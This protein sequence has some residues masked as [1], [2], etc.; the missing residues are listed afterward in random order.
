MIITRSN[1]RAVFNSDEGIILRPIDGL[2]LGEFD[3]TELLTSDVY[4]D[5]NSYCN[6]EGF[7]CW[8]N[9]WINRRT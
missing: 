3:G 4:I 1:D 7:Y 6:L 8:N 2:P 5:V 9:N